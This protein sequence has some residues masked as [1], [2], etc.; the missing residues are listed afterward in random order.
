MLQRV[1]LM[2]LAV[3]LTLSGPVA[4]QSGPKPMA[5]SFSAAEKGDWATASALAVRAGAGGPELIEWLRL[6]A[7]EGTPAEVLTFLKAHPDW[8]GLR[9]LRRRAEAGF[10]TASDAQ[11]L[12][13]FAEAAPQTGGGALRHVQA[14]ARS[15]QDAAAKAALVTGWRTLDLLD[16]EQSAFLADHGATLTP[17]HTERLENAMWGARTGDVRAMLPLVSPGWQALAKAWTALENGQDDGIN[18]LIAAVPAPLADHAVLAHARF[19]WRARKGRAPDAITLILDQSR[20]AD[21]L[22]RP[23]EWAARRLGMAHAEMRAGN[24]ARAYA[25]ASR[26]HLSG[27]SRLAELEWL[28]GYVAL[29]WQNDPARALTHFARLR[30]NV[31]S[32]ISLGRAHYWLGRA[33]EAAGNAPAARAAYTE[34]AKHQTAFYGLLAAERGGIAFDARLAGNERFPDWREAP[35]RQGL[36]YKAGLLAYNAGNLGLAE[37]FL[38]HLAESQNRTG[39]GQ[40]GEVAEVINE[41]HLAVMIGK[42]AAG[43]GITLPRP[44]YPLHPMM[45]QNL[46]VPSELALS[47]ARR[48]SEF[49][50]VVV[51]GAGAEGLMQ[52]MPRTAA[53]VAGQLGISHTPR[54]MITDPNYNARIGSAYLARLIARYD[55][56]AV[57][58]SAAYNAGPSRP[59]RWMG[60]QGDPRRADVDVVDWIE[61]IPFAETRNYVMRVTESLPV[62]RA[63]LGLQPHPVPFSQELKGATL[64]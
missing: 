16:V 14:L 34:G 6:R 37:T 9:L 27:G 22:G 2:M 23:E 59:D 19:D 62:Y 8:P 52:V 57:L 42:E 36:V 61:A 60:E 54:R 56:N 13:F 31:A 18:A 48:E 20:S 17:H 24:P 30:D 3:W 46:P 29:R 39:L 12:A 11:V 50:P 43:R 28:A 53:E 40:L 26:H 51:S 47:I 55:G 21:R 63:R 49:D 25:L 32:P 38:T 64:R 15:G 7:G 41:P 44:Y 35:F 5:L 58:V 45:A 10:A 33:H 1:I 4:A